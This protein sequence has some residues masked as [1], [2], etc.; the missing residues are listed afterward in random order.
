MRNDTWAGAPILLLTLAAAAAAMM[1]ARLPAAEIPTTSAA[2]IPAR[3]LYEVLVRRVDHAE[4]TRRTKNAR[5]KDPISVVR[6]DARGE[7]LLSVA[8][9]VVRVWDV[10]GMKPAAEPIISKS[11]V[12]A[13]DLSADGTLLLIADS[14]GKLQVVRIAAAAPAIWGWHADGGFEQAGFTPDGRSVMAIERGGRSVRLR[15]A[16]TGQETVTINDD[17]S[18]YRLNAAISRDGKRI[19]TSSLGPTRVWSAQTGKPLATVS[20]FGMMFAISPDGALVAGQAQAGE[21]TIFDA[22]SGKAVSHIDSVYRRDS[23]VANVQ[24]LAFSPDGQ[25]LAVARDDVG[26]R[27]WDARTGRPVS[28]GLNAEWGVASPTILFTPEGKHVVLGDVHTASVWDVRTG[29]RTDRMDNW[30][31]ST[32][33]LALAMSPDGRYVAVNF[34]DSVELWERRR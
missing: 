30:G 10:P 33:D 28:E 15:D 9:D 5:D 19:V 12:V 23:Q 21:V 13:A 8:N 18:K 32:Y 22:S 26:V 24:A 31:P 16:A 7:R 3:P 6:F 34:A 27:L 2:T 29:K 17:T 1:G 25:Y 20:V 4:A 14:D 11:R